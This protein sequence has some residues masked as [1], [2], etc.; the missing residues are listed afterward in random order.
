MT[1]PYTFA[2]ATTA[3]PLAQLDSNF[4]SPITLGNVA[5]TLSNTYTS[6]GNLTLTNVTV[7][8][9]SVAVTDLTYTGTLTGGTGVVNLGSGQFYK[10]AS[11]NVGIGT[12]S[13]SYNL[14]IGSS[15][16]TSNFTQRI[17]SGGSYAAMARY[18]LSGTGTF[19]VGF[20]NSGSVVNNAPTGVASIWMQQAYPLVF[21]TNGSERMRITSAGNVG[22]GTSSPIAKLD[23]GGASSGQTLVFSNT[24]SNSGSRIA[25]NIG[26]TTASLTPTVYQLIQAQ[27]GLSGYDNQTNLSFWT[28]NGSTPNQ[29]MILD[30][31]GN[32]S[33]V[34]AITCGNTIT[35]NV[36]G[37]NYSGNNYASSGSST[38]MNMYLSGTQ[39]FYVTNA[40]TIYTRGSTTIQ[41]ISDQSLKTNIVDIPYGL[42]TVVALKPRQF[43]W[44][45]GNGDGKTG[46][47]GFIAQEVNAVLPQI[48]DKFGDSDLMTL[49]TTDLIPVLVKAI[50]ELNAKVTALEAQLGVK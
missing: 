32:L 26:Y 50:Q 31:N 48:T 36:N 5:M 44:T 16:A 22:V 45:E 27:T 37:P 11:G 40:G 43:D 14:D 6:I 39:Q 42:D 41:A 3:I 15:S 47:L 9:G 18:D 24:G 8:S 20:N 12:S 28:C 25:M 13:P 38:F 46:K 1:I 10:D 2:N 35:A 34:S 4:A 23:L 7:S 30:Q 19:T 49:G 21:G 33:V 17:Q 29:N